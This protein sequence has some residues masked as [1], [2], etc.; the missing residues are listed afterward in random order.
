MSH[1][2]VNELIAD[3][4]KSKDLRRCGNLCRAGYDETSQLRRTLPICKGKG[5]TI[6]AITAPDDDS[7]WLCVLVIE[8]YF[9]SQVS[10]ARRSSVKLPGPRFARTSLICW[11]MRSS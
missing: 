9:T 4:L 8:N 11:F 6:L 5:A 3:A 7:N 1:Y 2:V 10:P